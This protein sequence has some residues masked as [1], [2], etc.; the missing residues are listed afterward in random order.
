MQRICIYTKDIPIITGKSYRYCR[1]IMKNIRKIN[2]KEKHQP[3]SVFELS[4]YLGIDVQEVMKIV[5]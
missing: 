1:T 2:N 5:K 3:V 4:N